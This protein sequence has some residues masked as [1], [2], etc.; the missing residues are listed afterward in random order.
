MGK[1]SRRKGHDFE[2]EVAQALRVV[3]PGA[4]RQLEYHARDARGIDIQ[5]TGE[6][7]FQCKRLEKYA[8]VNTIEEIQCD[9]VFGD[10]PVLVTAGNGKEWMAVLPFD[11]LLR[12]IQAAQK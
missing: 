8:S 11:D 5:E 6:F 12:L 10:V 7:R 3:F 4:R 9:R 1:W 2:R